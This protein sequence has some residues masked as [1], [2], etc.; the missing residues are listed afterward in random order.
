MRTFPYSGR[1]LIA[2]L[3]VVSLLMGCRKRSEGHGQVEVVDIQLGNMLADFSPP[4][5]ADL[6][7]QVEADGGWKDGA[8][9]NGL[10]LLRAQQQDEPILATVEEALQLKNDSNENNQKIKNALGRVAEEDSDVNFEATITRHT[11]QTLRSTNPLLGSSVTEFEVAD[12]TS[13]GLFN[14]DANFRPFAIKEHVE[15]WVSS[16]DGMYDKVT[17]RKDLAWSDGTPLT[18]HDVEFTHRVIMTKEVAIPAVR[19]GPDKLKCVKAYDDHT[20]VFFHQE[21][22]ETNTW[23]I[24]WPVIPKHVFQETVLQDP[25]LADSKEHVAINEKPIGA[26]PYA[27]VSASPNE[28]LLARNE[29][30]YMHDGKQVRDKP[31]FKQVRFRINPDASTALLGM[32]AGDVDNMIL[33]AAQWST[34]T[35]GEDFYR[36]NTK[37][38]N[39]EWVSFSF[40]WNTKTPFFSD[41][42]V[43][44]AMSHA[45]DHK[46]LLETLRYGRDEPCTGTYHR[47]SRWHP[48]DSNAIKNAPTP[49]VQDIAKAK[50]L[51]DEAG[52]IDSDGDG[53]RDKEING[54]KTKFE[55]TVVVRNSKERTDICE[56]LRQSL[57]PIGIV[58]NIGPL[59]TA[60]LQQKTSDKEFDAYFGGWGTGADPDTSENLFGTNQDRNYCS[61]SN[62]IVDEMFGEGRKLK[63]DRKKWRE[64]KLWSDTETREYLGI[65]PALADQ[66]PE[67]E[68]CYATIQ[69][70]LWRD[71]PYT[72]LFYRNAYYAYSKKL[73]GYTYSPR[74]PFGFSPGFNSVW[75]TGQ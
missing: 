27:F 42:R 16:A 29:S 63:K 15:S 14:F 45:F 57:R 19:S 62:A 38:R 48:G 65:D 4:T 22:L 69:A 47:T 56:L 20:V 54:K 6:D 26:G 52:W 11:P 24:L 2:I 35:D 46:E 13:F 64:L 43:R 53:Y 75:M 17:L 33:E 8:L 28:V 34:Q 40:F 66:Q 10:D 23:N 49:Q 72:W 59:E 31:Y 70:V 12:L 44:Q 61:Y 25:T 9:L 51:L 60:T 50:Q 37:S 67:R 3:C 1:C 55:F 7:K 58:C 30:Y 74:G 71:K 36:K 21:P 73:R 5:L 68:D 39:I 32:K 41:V 18:A